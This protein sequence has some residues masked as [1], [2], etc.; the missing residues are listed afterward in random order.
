MERKGA[1]S[2]ILT[3][4]IFDLVEREKKGLKTYGVTMDRTDLT[5]KEWLNH[6]YEELLDAVLYLKKYGLS[7]GNKEPVKRTPP[8]KTNRNNRTVRKTTKAS[9][10][11]NNNQRG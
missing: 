11:K 5:D 1:M 10:L 3:S 2:K 8:I 7:N 6:L 4:V 9:K